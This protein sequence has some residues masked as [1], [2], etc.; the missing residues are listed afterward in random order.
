[1]EERLRE[2]RETNRIHRCAAIVDENPKSFPRGFARR[3]F[4]RRSPA[5]GGC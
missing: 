2:A 5:A 4:R 1:M 3:P